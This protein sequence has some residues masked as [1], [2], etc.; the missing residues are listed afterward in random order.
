M[1]LFLC[2]A[3]YNLSHEMN[4]IEKLIENILPT[5]MQLSPF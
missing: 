2:I 1:N 4:F 5:F 3:F